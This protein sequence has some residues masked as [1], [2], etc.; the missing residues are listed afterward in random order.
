M[1]SELEVRIP[2]FTERWATHRG[3]HSSERLHLLAADCDCSEQ[4]DVK[5]ARTKEWTA[6]PIMRV[7][8]QATSWRGFP[9]NH[10]LNKPLLSE[11][12]QGT[13]AKA[14]Q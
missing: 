12:R 11:L 13:I 4:A 10:S 6:N 1:A 5:I 14:S 2:A 8:E 9:N 3:G 7:M